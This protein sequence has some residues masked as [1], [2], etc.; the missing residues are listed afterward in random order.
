MPRVRSNVPIPVETLRLLVLVLA[1]ERTQ[2]LRVVNVELISF[3]YLQHNSAQ[4]SHVGG[5]RVNVTVAIAS[6]YPDGT[7]DS[8][9]HRFRSIVADGVALRKGGCEILCSAELC[10]SLSLFTEHEQLKHPVS[11][12]HVD[13]SDCCPSF[14]SLTLTALI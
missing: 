12:H 1:R 14:G 9:Q 10:S 5:R 6:Y 2:V 11:R 13:S 4:A 8:L 3:L 7:R